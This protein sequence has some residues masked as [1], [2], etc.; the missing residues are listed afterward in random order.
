MP[1]LIRVVMTP[2]YNHSS[3]AVLKNAID[4]VFVS[5]AFRNKPAGT[6]AYSGGRIAGARGRTPGVDLPSKP[7]WSR[8]ATPC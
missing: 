8:C 6:A 5:Y 7:K 3:P 2:E 4:T 1:R